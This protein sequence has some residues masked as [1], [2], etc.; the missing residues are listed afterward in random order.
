MSAPER[1]GGSAAR[2]ANDALGE[3]IRQM[4]QRTT[5]H[6]GAG[7]MVILLIAAFALFAVLNPR[8]FLGPVNLQNIMVASPEVGVLAIAM[9]LAMLTGGID[10]SLVSIANLSAIS[11]ATVF[12]AVEAIDPAAA[13]SMTLPLVLLGVAV[14]VACGVLNGVLVSVVGITPILAMADR[15]KRLGKPYELHY[16]VWAVPT[17]LSLCRWAHQWEYTDQVS[18][19]GCLFISSISLFQYFL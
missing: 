3:R 6:R 17:L 9:M 10:L 14:G 19:W 16:A 18:V 5:V 4:L 12:L 13:E 7:R 2:A 8:V 11:V 15:L 1:S